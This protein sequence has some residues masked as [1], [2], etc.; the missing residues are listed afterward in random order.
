M[1]VDLY[2]KVVLTI[3]T[4]FVGILV[5]KDVDLVSKAKASELDL[6]GIKVEDASSDG[7]TTF[8]I[9][10]NDKIEKP[11]GKSYE[12]HECKIAFD[13]IPTYIITNKRGGKY[14]T[15]TLRKRDD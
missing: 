11:F 15:L 1:K 8:F 5:F 4:I 2:T 9:Y 12:G 3:L 14:S 10:E 6:S 13:D 7:E